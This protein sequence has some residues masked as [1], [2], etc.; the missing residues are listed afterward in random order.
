MKRVLLAVGSAVLA[1]TLSAA[2]HPQ[3]HGPH[4]WGDKDKDGKCDRTGQAVGQ[5]RE[6][7]Q[8]MAGKRQG[9]GQRRHGS[10]MGCCRGGQG[11]AVQTTPAPEPKK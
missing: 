4:A 1:F 6:Q 11:P 9:K 8:G 7:R 10:Q 5:G 2:A 3:G